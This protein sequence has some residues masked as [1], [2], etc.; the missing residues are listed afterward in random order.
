[1]I[2]VMDAQ[3]KTLPDGPVEVS[4][5]N[6]GIVNFGPATGDKAGSSEMKRDKLIEEF[7]TRVAIPFVYRPKDMEAVFWHK[8][9]INVGV[10][11]TSALLKLPYKA[12]KRNHP[13]A[14]PEAQA[15]LERA[16]REVIAIAQARNIPLGESN[17][18]TWYDTV[19]KLS[20][21]GYS[22]MAQD[23]IAGRPM[24]T[25]IFGATVSAL[26]KKL[27]IGT[28]QNDVFCKMLA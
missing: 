28:P 9:M 15:M 27:G 11:Q 14:S 1:M 5:K 2:N 25:D 12:F 7:F 4:F 8:F 16:M 18:E 6:R 3:R 26:G 23:A 17:I 19:E 10:N 13:A 22:S 21:D 20:D 24:E